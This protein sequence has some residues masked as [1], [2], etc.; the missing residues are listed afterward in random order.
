[1]SQ[2]DPFTQ[3][4]IKNALV[5]IGDEM[6]LAMAKTSMS[7]II[8]E[9]L[10]YSVG[11]TNARGDLI[12]QGN[13][14][15]VF[16]GMI[17]SLVQDIL[18][19]FQ[20]KGEI[21]PE[22]VF[23]SNDPYKG[24]GT[25]LCDVAIAKPIFYQDELVGFAVN[26]AHWV[27]VGGMAAGSFT[28]DAKEIFQE[29][30][31]IPT[32]KVMERGKPVGG[33]LEILQSN[34]RLPKDSM[35]DFWAGM[36]AN[37][38]AEVRLV[39]LFDRYGREAMRQ[40]MDDLLDYGETM[41]AAE[42]KKLP[43][44]T[45][46]AE[47]WIDDDGITN[48]PLKVCVRIDITEDKFKVD[49]TGSA[50]QTTGPINNSRTGLVSAVRTIFKALTNPGIPA[51]GGCFRA[52]EVVCPDR[53]LFTAERPAPVS[54]YWETMLYAEDL[55][56]K[57]LADHLPE[58][59]TAGHVLSVCAFIFSGTHPKTSEPTILVG[60]LVGGWGAMQDRDGLNGQFSVADGETYNFPIEVTE[61]KYGVKVRRYQ[62]HNDD[63]GA[64]QFRGGK[65]VALEYEM[66]ND[67][68]TFTGSFGRSKFPPWGI[69][70]G[71]TGSPNY[72][73]IL[74]QGR[75]ANPPEIMAKPARL[76]LRKGDVVRMVTATGGGWGD[77][78]LRERSAVEQDLRDGFITADQAR[79]DY[80]YAP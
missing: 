3:E 71:Q 63:G 47:D 5:A 7:P 54:T 51:N 15:T 62:F 28:T 13:G 35:G 33:I 31:Q 40:A 49:F 36:A 69:A 16:L 43:Q 52:I 78:R 26:K 11:I 65:G 18:E 70:G 8:Y 14:T 22:D 30:I 59:L 24:G 42:L 58:R 29:G 53:T 1:M 57:A 50:P 77:P 45:F 44:G 75:R 6:F 32:I 48:D 61:A 72:V 19:M 76:P 12:A 9:A 37:K 46:Y 27:D 38:V 60:P 56:W 67:G 34:I 23:I 17:D 74:R 73:E 39:D 68:W 25:H 4:I 79:A 64:G 10:D 55:I 21:F 41:I 2:N 66:P 20:S 80:G